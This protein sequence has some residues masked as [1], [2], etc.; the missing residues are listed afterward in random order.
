MNR[1]KSN[2]ITTGSVEKMQNEQQ[3]KD[4]MYYCTLLFWISYCLLGFPR[5]KRMVN[6][7]TQVNELRKLKLTNITSGMVKT[8][9]MN[10]KIRTNNTEIFCI[11]WLLLVVALI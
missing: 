7:F 2:K 11:D 6:P 1:D 5:T 3:K 9:K 8:I 10:N 4:C